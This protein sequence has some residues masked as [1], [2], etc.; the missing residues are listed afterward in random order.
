MISVAEAVSLVKANT[1][2]LSP[3]ALSLRQ[4]P[5]LLLAGDVHAKTSLPPF[6]QSAMDGYAF[7]YD[8][9]LQT[10]ELRIRGEIA[11]GDKPE[12][13]YAKGTAVRI[14]TGAP[15]PSWADTIVMQEKT[16][17]DNGNVLIT[18]G[19]LTK[20]SNVRTEGAEIGKGET[21]MVKGSVLTPAA[22]GFLA[23]LG[24]TDVSVHPKPSVHLIVTGNELQ[25]P[26]AP[27]AA[28]RVYES[29]SVMLQAALQQLHINTISTAVVGDDVAGLNDAIQTGLEK[30]DLLLLTG[31]VSVGDHDY[32]VRCLK[33]CGV[34]EVFHKVAQ[35][36]GKPLYCGVKEGKVVFGLPGNP[37]SVLS[38]FYNY[39]VVAI[40]KM[41]GRKNLLERKT[42]PLLTDFCKNIALTQF[43]KATYSADGV[44]PSGA[45][46]SFRLSSFA[47]ADCLIVLPEEKRD[48]KRGDPVETLVLPYL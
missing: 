28:G 18:D 17:A 14:F 27:L 48:F 7:R 1:P 41:T 15:L 47:A 33:T 35:R 12:L 10:T 6:R 25:Q 39:V 32:V 38:C 20:G 23:G 22:T 5:G 40:E 45:Q 11:A 9:Y 44:L 2:L 19:Q 13:S 30:A 43:L 16:K 29:N 24:I 36:P 34:R 37:A 21:A 8:D 26:G 3:Q 4:S 42:L 31:G 46:E